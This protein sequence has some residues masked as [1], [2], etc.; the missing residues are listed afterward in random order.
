MR[1]TLS[2]PGTQR[3]TAGMSIMKAQTCSGEAGTVIRCSICTRRPVYTVGHGSSGRPAPA[4]LLRRTAPDYDWHH[5][6]RRQC[7]DESHLVRVPRR[8]DLAE[9]RT[10]PGLVQAHAARPAGD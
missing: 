2:T 7:P 1:A 9:R 6:S 10:E 3:L 4:T 8:S 5:P